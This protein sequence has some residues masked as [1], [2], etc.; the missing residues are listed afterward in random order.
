MMIQAVVEF[1][2]V[3]V[4]VAWTLAQCFGAA[5]AMLFTAASAP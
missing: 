4:E 3:N 2:T 1:V 5:A